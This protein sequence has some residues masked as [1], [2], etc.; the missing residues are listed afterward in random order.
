LFFI[1]PAV[2]LFFIGNYAI[3]ILFLFVA[4]FSGLR[5]FLNAALVLEEVGNMDLIR[6]TTSQEKWLKQSRLNTIIKDISRSRSQGAW[7]SLL[8]IFLLAFLGL[9]GLAISQQSDTSS[10]FEFTYMPN[11]EYIQAADLAYPTC[12][13]GKGIESLGSSQT[14]IA[15]FAFVAV[16]ACA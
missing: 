9:F 2:S 11:F 3:A 4:V 1:Y 15:D 6:G 8:C 16:L 13:I 14:A 12:T 5:E 7:T 10:D